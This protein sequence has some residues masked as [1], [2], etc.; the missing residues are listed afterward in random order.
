MNK[1]NYRPV[2]I[3]P[4]INKVFEKR[5]SPQLTAHFE[6]I[7]SVSLSAYWKQHSCFSTLLRLTEDWKSELD[8]NNIIGMVLR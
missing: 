2:T 5:G 1:T 4:A 6:V 3:L 7:F 8:H